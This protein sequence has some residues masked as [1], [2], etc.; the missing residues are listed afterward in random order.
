MRGLSRVFI[1]K[2]KM[3][4]AKCKMSENFL[5]MLE[6]CCAIIQFVL[7]IEVFSNNFQA[8]QKATR[9]FSKR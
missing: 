4:K 3:L 6:N 5:A 7:D 1:K 8:Y 9:K 2:C